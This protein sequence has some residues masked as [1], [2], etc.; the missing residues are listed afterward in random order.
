MRIWIRPFSL[1]LLAH[2]ISAIAQ[3]L[4]I[5]SKVMSDR[6]PVAT[7][8]SYLARDHVRM[9]HGDGKE[10]IVDFRS[11][12]MTTLDA[13]NRTYYVTT[14]QDMEQFAA[15][16]R[17]QMNSAEVKKAQEQLKSLSPDERKKVDAAMGGVAGAF[18]VRKAGTTRRI[19]G[20]LC[21]DWTIAFGELSRTDEC[22]TRELQFPVQAWDMYREFAESMKSV[23]AAFGPMAGS[24]ARMHQKLKNM[25]GYPLSTTTKINIL[26]NRTTT[27]SEVAEIRR[28]PI[29]A[30]VWE[31]PAGYRKVGNPMLKALR[32]SR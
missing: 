25:K 13:R 24:V 18:D 15:R 10:L 27:A 9:A 16:M 32:S 20:Y 29:P 3:D 19:A 4:T 12:E 17:Q 31:V 22:L 14:R 26:G 30:S 23:M 7:T 21:E 28:G 1:I 2:G 8:I 11:G 6:K 5:V